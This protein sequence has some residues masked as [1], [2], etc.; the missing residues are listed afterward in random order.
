MRR[1][2]GLLQHVA[3]LTLR[4]DRRTTLLMLALIIAQAAVIALT[5]LS[6]RWLVD[7]GTGG[8]VAMVAAAVALGAAAH[9]LSAAGGR[10]LSNMQLYLTARVTVAITGEVL[11]MTAAVPTVEHVERAEHLN[12]LE[13]LAWGCGSLAWLPWVSLGVVA[14]SLSLAVSV[15]LLGLVNPLLCALAALAVPPLL[16]SRRAHELVRR[17]H[18]ATAELNRWEQRLHDLCT[19]PGPARELFITGAGAEVDRRAAALWRAVLARETAARVRAIV[20]QGG[21]WLVYGAGFVAALLLVSELTRAGR[22]TLGDA[23]LVFSLATQLQGQVKLVVEQVGRLAE[24]GQ[25]VAHYYWLREYA[26]R[27]RRAGAPPPARLRHGIAL[28]AVC[29]RYPGSERDVLRDLD[30]RLP[31][32]STVALVGDNGAGKTTLVNLLTGVYEPT[33]GQVTVDG[34]PLSRFDR[35]SWQAGV[36]GVLQD[37]VRFQVLAREAIGVGDVRRV[38]SDAAV[39]EAVERAGAAGVVARLP[40]GLRTQLGRVFG[41]AEPSSGQWQRLALARGVMRSAP[42]LALLDEPTAALDPQTEYELFRQFDQQARTVNAVGGITVLVSH[43]LSTVRMAD[44]IVVVRGGRVVESGTHAELMAAG[45]EYAQSF[46][47]QQQAY[48]DEPAAP[49]AEARRPVEPRRLT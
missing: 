7:G 32:G 20:W 46:R 4:T 2:W 9:G 13:R 21:G 15:L 29:F 23:V 22:A 37:F 24:S 8:S 11:H 27:S 44:L 12:R 25:V 16:A 10:V 1:W 26:N 31:A 35:A 19:Q 14:T 45:G 39:S 28:E 47:L 40:D 42:L 49:G 38:R 48:T 17:A 33:A 5:V 34:T 36:S 3:R 18:D 41:G 30:L 6:Q 43:R